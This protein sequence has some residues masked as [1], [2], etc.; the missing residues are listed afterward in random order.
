VKRTEIQASTFDKWKARHGGE[1]ASL[2][3]FLIQTKHMLA[4]VAAGAK[5]IRR[6]TQWRTKGKKRIATEMIEIEHRPCPKY[7]VVLRLPR[8]WRVEDYP[9]PETAQRAWENAYIAIAEKLGLRFDETCRGVDRMFF[10][11]RVSADRLPEAESVEIEGADCPALDLAPTLQTAIS[12]EASAD[13]TATRRG[14]DKREHR[15]RK[16]Q[17]FKSRVI[18]DGMTGKIYSG[19]QEWAREVGPRFQL[20]NAVRDRGEVILDL[21]GEVDGKQHIECPFSAEHTSALAHP[22]RDAAR[23]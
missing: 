14:S 21:R 23:F 20:A 7:R 17:S 9:D 19:L 2:E 16:Q 8:P 22:I 5:E 3:A 1:D 12:G 6:F 11:T 13:G 15:D 10:L 18:S 4:R